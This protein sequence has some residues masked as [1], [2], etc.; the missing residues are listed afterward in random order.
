VIAKKMK[1]ANV[2]QTNYFS[3]DMVTIDDVTKSMQNVV[4]DSLNKIYEYQ[5]NDGYAFWP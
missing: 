2:L 3:G 4:T 5:T 1:Q